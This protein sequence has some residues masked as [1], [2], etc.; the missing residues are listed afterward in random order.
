[1]PLTVTSDSV[2]AAAAQGI[3]G[4]GEVSGNGVAF[5]ILLLAALDL[6][7]VFA[8]LDLQPGRFHHIYC[9]LG[10][11]PGLKLPPGSPHWYRLQPVAQPPGWPRGTEDCTP[12]LEAGYST[13]HFSL[14]HQRGPVIFS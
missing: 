11:G 14:Y 9:D 4:R 12:P 2:T 10:I 5:E 3:G 8:C 6:K 7:G 13:L 1:M